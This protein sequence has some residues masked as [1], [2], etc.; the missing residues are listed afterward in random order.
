MGWARKRFRLPGVLLAVLFA[1]ALAS[2]ALA[3]GDTD[4]R[5]GGWGLANAMN[6]AREHNDRLADLEPGVDRTRRVFQSRLTRHG[7]FQV[8]RE[9]CAR[10]DL[11]RDLYTFWRVGGL[12]AVSLLGLTLV[13][14]G[15]MWM[16]EAMGLSQQ[17]RARLLMV[18]CFVGVMIVG[19]AF[20]VWQGLYTGTF[21]FFTLE[22]GE[23]NPVGAPTT[24]D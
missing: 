24:Y 20:F 16:I 18:N 2:P 22:L 10:L 14:G 7:R 11:E 5:C 8:G 9:V 1:L 13:W 3:Q 12:L 21:G 23:F 15:M 17:G 19:V 4:I 6:W